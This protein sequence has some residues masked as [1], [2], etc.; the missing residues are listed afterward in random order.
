MSMSSLYLRGKTWRGK[1]LEN[2]RV[3]RWSLKTGSRAEARR[4]LKLYD[5]QSHQEP[6]PT[7]LKTPVT[8]DTAAT[9][10]IRYYEA[11]STRRPQEAARVLRTLTG[12]FGS[13][14]LADIDAS[15]ILRYVARR[16]AHGKAAN[17]VN[18]ELATLRCALRL[19]RELGHL[20]SVP[21]IRTLRPAPPRSGFFE[22]EEFEA[23]ARELPTDLAL[24]ARIAYTFGWRLTDEVLPL[25]RSQ[26]D[27]EAGTLRLPPGSTKNGDGCLVYL[28]PEL[29][30]GLAEQLA[31]VRTLERELGRVIPHVFPSLQGP[32]KGKQR[33]S[34]A[35]TWRHAC[36][37]AGLSGKWKRD[38]RRTA[39]RNMV[40]AGI[41]ERVAMKITGHRTRST[42]DRYHIV[43]PGDLRGAARKMADKPRTQEGTNL[44]QAS[45]EPLGL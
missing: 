6:I 1:S 22:L 9:D 8:W 16:R 32:H 5:S 40:N 31:R 28:T 45:R 21:I 27:L 13:W 38:L 2:G 11:Y 7:R 14:K 19:A 37:R 24:V 25:T 33:K 20:A 34:M 44:F 15:A 42:F 23:V 12:F 4:R 26:V 10:L 43:S 29:R 18:V 3:V 39:V 17:T 35:W 36:K 30:A 41:S